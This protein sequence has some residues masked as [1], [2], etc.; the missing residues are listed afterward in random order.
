MCGK[1]TYKVQGTVEILV[2]SYSITAALL[3][4]IITSLCCLS[5]SSLKPRN[6]KEHSIGAS[7]LQ[8]C[9]LLSEPGKSP[10]S[11]CFGFYI[12]D[13][14][15]IFFPLPTF[16]DSQEGQPGWLIFQVS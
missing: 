15:I 16:Q 11:L 1:V 3:D 12:S 13:M 2:I 10:E 8:F 6:R 9:H 5:S 14:G 7:R 4:L